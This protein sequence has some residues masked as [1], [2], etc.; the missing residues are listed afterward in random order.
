MV[1]LVDL[2]PVQDL[3]TSQITRD[4]TQLDINLLTSLAYMPSH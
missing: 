2:A 4:L 3:T 1:N